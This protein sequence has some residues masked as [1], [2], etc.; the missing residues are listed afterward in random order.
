MKKVKIGLGVFLAAVLIGSFFLS[1][2]HA[3]VPYTI[4]K[5]PVQDQHSR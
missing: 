2:A 1:P 5:T 3:V 4:W